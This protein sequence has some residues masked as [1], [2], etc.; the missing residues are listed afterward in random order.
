MPEVHRKQ[1]GLYIVI[2]I[3][4]SYRVLDAKPCS[5]EFKVLLLIVSQAKHVARSHRKQKH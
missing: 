3:H 4:K 5:L 1:M 2:V